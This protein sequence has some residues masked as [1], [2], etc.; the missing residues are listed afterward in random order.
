MQKF[1]TLRDGRKIELDSP[2]EDAA[3]TAAAMANPDARPF[4]DEEWEAVKPFVRVGRPRKD[5]PKV[6]TGI[7]L[8]ADVLAAFKA[9]G[10][11]WQ[12]RLN[13]ALREWLATHP[14]V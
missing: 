2:E 8:D 10:K 5:A 13:A 4:T 1:L 3:I 11:G 7:R 6:F 9:S 14:T 12:T